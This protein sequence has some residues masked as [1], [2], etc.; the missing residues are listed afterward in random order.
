M[1]IEHPV[2]R[3]FS[4]LRQERNVKRPANITLLTEL[5]WHVGEL[6]FY[7]HLAPNGADVGQSIFYLAKPPRSGEMFIAPVNPFVPF[8]IEGAWRL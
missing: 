7:K 4:Q 2:A 5:Q 6:V 8:R 1:F 3:L